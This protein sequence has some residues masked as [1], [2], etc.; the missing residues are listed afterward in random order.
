MQRNVPDADA[1]R[2]ANVTFPQSEANKGGE[3]A[4][5]TAE[6]CGASTHRIKQGH[7]KEIHG[8]RA[9]P[10]GELSQFLWG[11]NRSIH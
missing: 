8:S 6:P 7:Q 5:N 4:V 2:C 10:Q 9:P 1:L 3:A 11:S